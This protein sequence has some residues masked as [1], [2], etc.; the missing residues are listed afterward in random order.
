MP[1]EGSSNVSLSTV[2]SELYFLISRFLASGPCQRASEALR[3]ELTEH[4]LLPKRLDWEGRQHERSYEN[5]VSLNRHISSSHLLQIC[6]RLG[7]LLDKDINSSVTGL[8]SLLGAGQQSLLR[9]KESVI[10]PR[11]RPERHLATY[12]HRP[13]LP[14]VNLVVPSL[15]HVTKAREMTGQSRRDLVCPIFIHSKVSMHARKLG[16]LSAVYCV[17]FDRTG[18]YIFTGADD[19][20]IKIWFA[21]SGRLI[22]TLRGHNSEITD[23]AV[24][25]ENTLLASGSCD[26]IIRVWCLRTKAPVAV[27]QAHTGMITSLQFCPQARGEHRIL[28]STGGDGC[29]CFWT[30]NV[31]T[32]KFNPK[33]AKFIE[34]SRAGAQML[35]SSFSPGGVFLA[36][37]SADHVIRVYFL[38]VTTPEKICELEAHTDR[39]DSIC[40][41]NSGERFVSGSRDGTARIWRYDRQEWKSIILSMS[42]KLSS[43]VKSETEDKGQKPRVTMVAWNL[44]DNLVVTAVNDC[45]LK[46]W[47]SHHGKLLHVL[48]AHEDEVFV[49]EHSPMDPRIFLSAGHDGYVIMWDLNT[50]NK[51][52]SYFNMIEGQGHGA[53]FD[54][55]FCPDGNSFVATDSH[56]HLLL[57][58]FGSNEKYKQIPQEL[59]FHTDYRPL[60][61]DSNNYVLDEQTQQPPHLM[62]PP[63]L[64]DI[65]GNPYPPKFQRLVPGREHCKENLLVPQMAVNETGDQEVVGERVS[66]D[67]DEQLMP[68]PVAP[69]NLDSLIQQL[70]REQDNRLAASGSPRVARSNSASG[71]NH[72]HRVG[73][74]MS[75]ETEGVRQS[76]GNINQQATQSDLAAWSRRIIVKELHPSLLSSCEEVRMA[77]A[78]IEAKKFLAERKKKPVYFHHQ[79]EVTTPVTPQNKSRRRPRV[80]QHSD[81]TSPENEETATNRLATRALYDTEEEEDENDQ[82]GLWNSSSGSD[83]SDYSDWVGDNNTTS[84]Q[85]PKRTSLRRR[86]QRRLTSSEEE[87]E[88][89]SDTNNDN[90]ATTSRRPRPQRKKPEP[91]E[92]KPNKTTRR[93]QQI[94]KKMGGVEELPEEFRPPEWLTDTKPRKTPYVP[95]MGDEVM[96]FRQGHALYLQAVKR[97]AAYNVNSNKNQPWNKYPHLR[98]QEYVKIVG[99]KY[100]VRPPRLCCLKLAFIDPETGKTSGGSFNIKY[101]D[102][103]D[104]IDFLVL[105]QTYDVAMKRRW[106]AND[107][108]RSMIDDAWW[109]GT[110][111]SQ[112]PFQ[113]EYPDSMFQCF[114]VHWDNG[115]IEKISPWDM[116]PIG[117]CQM[118]D[119]Q[120][121]GVPVTQDEVKSLM[122]TPTSGEW[123]SCGRDAE[124]ERIIRCME[125]VMEHSI[126]EPFL[127]PVD[128]NAFPIYAIVIE[129][130]IDLTTIK[131]R[132]ENRFYRRVNSLQFD[133]RYIENNANT[134][135]EP[136]TPIVKSA[137]IT[138]EILLRIISDEDC[139][140]PHSIISQLCQGEEFSWGSSSSDSDREENSQARKRKRGGDSDIPRKRQKVEQRHKTTNSWKDECLQL[141]VTML[142]CEDSEPFR[143]PVN[144]ESYPNYNSIID[145]PMDLGTVK[146]NLENGEYSD[147]TQLCK[148]IRL[149]FHNSKVFNTNKRSRIYTMT[150]R[151][152]AMFEEQIKDIVIDWKSAKKRMSRSRSITENSRYTERRLT[153]NSL[154]SEDTPNTS[155]A[156]PGPSSSGLMATRR[157]QRLLSSSTTQADDDEEEEIEVDVDSISGPSTRS[158]HSNYVSKHTRKSGVK[159]DEPNHYDS[160]TEVESDTEEEEDIKPSNSQR[161]RSTKTSA[162]KSASSKFSIKGKQPVTSNGQHK[163][164]AATGTIKPRR[165]CVDG[166]F[167][168]EE[169]MSLKTASPSHSSSSSSSST[170]VDSN[171]SSSSSSSSSDSD[172]DSSYN[173]M[174]AKPSRQ[175]RRS[176][177]V[178]PSVKPRLK[179]SDNGFVID[180]NKKK[181]NQ[182][183]KVKKTS[184][185]ATSSRRT[186]ASGTVKRTTRNQGRQTVRYQEDSDGEPEDSR[187]LEGS[188]TSSDSDYSIGHDRPDIST[189]S[190]G[191]VRKLTARA[192]ASLMGE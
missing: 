102:M 12:H 129:Y 53:V 67:N 190:R 180:K 48:K 148:D 138:T 60:M 19:A 26:K 92:K 182:N 154:S 18:Q 124:C 6:Q 89:Q 122:Y 109:M 72:G 153:I 82:S 42:T 136:G 9:T 20:L 114:N 65:D 130:P 22:D 151:L 189:S 45:T 80:G 97:H 61:R 191:R 36:T 186:K 66:E 55:K 110:I 132:L 116:E 105:K 162:P 4:Q 25:F 30:W 163:T 140:D 169:K 141:L 99:I 146:E 164:R 160:E 74:R 150:L 23:I 15:S 175:T 117:Q 119:E 10:H 32:N 118:P 179:A 112:E 144:L 184:N 143:E 103:S 14:P 71:S 107:R 58:G 51:I 128:L 185:N 93:R 113:Q 121:G 87:D 13:L 161:K 69:N 43:C 38:H 149:V 95:Q 29:V 86:K 73:M 47:D 133:V 126:A 37:G 166:S 5:L 7:P 171:D 178:R 101:H 54:C 94:V 137:Q 77:H 127:T 78:E 155:S 63:F 11:W 68:P 35:C 125:A 174:D 170:E 52:K 83:S 76:L 3:Q 135:N 81:T 106:K 59:F 115:E 34:R 108:F 123:P 183:S 91:K 70:Q 21:A 158:S 147:P 96:Y 75:G 31:T 27:L 50:G 24:N 33:P 44:D 192:R 168:D 41:S 40:Y 85:P 145:E 98:E 167:T 159:K 157:T 57:F 156:R 17:A 120:G 188:G 177:P 1:S 142:H 2:E 49:L 104:V 176:K 134:F 172:S 88:D 165:Y 139:T 79:G 56:G 90:D 64:V 28:S 152:S 8:Q 39:V 46:V 173:S 62:P 187:G 131:S 111:V 100:E 16:H 84:L 181:T